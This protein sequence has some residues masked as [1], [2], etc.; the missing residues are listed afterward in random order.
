MRS[1]S[2]R[3]GRRAA[4]AARPRAG[5]RAA[6]GRALDA[7][8]REAGVLYV[9]GHGLDPELG[10]RLER[11]ARAFFGGPIEDK[12]RIAMRHGGRAWRGYFPV[13]AERTSG[14]PDRK[15][16]LYFGE[17]LGPDEQRVRAGLPLHGPNLFPADGSLRQDVLACTIAGVKFTPAIVQDL[18]GL[19]RL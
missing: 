1:A 10:L 14:R 16:G 6:L 15:E 8:C 17:E 9:V 19:Q 7:A 2:G 18:R 4:A 13:G 5:A 11:A 3:A 12:Q